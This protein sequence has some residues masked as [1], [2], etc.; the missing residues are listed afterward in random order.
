MKVFSSRNKMFFGFIV[1]VVM[2]LVVIL[3][4]SLLK[5]WQLQMKNDLLRENN[6]LIEIQKINRLGLNAD[7]DG[8]YYFLSSK[9]DNKKQFLSSYIKLVEQV[10]IEIVS[11][12]KMLAK[13]ELLTSLSVFEKSWKRYLASNEHAFHLEKEGHLEEAKI[14]FTELS[15]KEIRSYN[16][17]LREQQKKLIEVKQLKIDKYYSILEQ[18]D[19]AGIIFFILFTIILGWILSRKIQLEHHIKTQK[20][21][22]QNVSHDIKTP[23]MSIQG[24]AQGILDGAIH[25]DKVNHSLQVIVKESDRLKRMVQEMILLSKLENEKNTF[26]WKTVPVSYLIEESIFRIHPLLKDKGITVGIPSSEPNDD[27]SPVVKVDPEKCLQAFINVL[28]NAIRHATH[29]IDISVSEQGNQ[30]FIDIK[31]DGEGIPA[32]TLPYLFERFVKGDNGENG[33]GLAVARAILELCGGNIKAW[34]HQDGGAVFRIMFP[35]VLPGS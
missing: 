23:L 5:D 28:S 27:A 14:A 22:Y 12:R 3:V 17:N 20:Q 9:A 30:V 25:G 32:E 24:Y 26:E 35:I 31:D 1:I 6:I 21:F 18:L 13:P 15:Y 8:A 19:M 33:L 4:N 16:Q 34:N 7:N 11:L 29:T 2:C 10:Q